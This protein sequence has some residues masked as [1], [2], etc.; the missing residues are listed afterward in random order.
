MKKNL[1]VANIGMQ[2]GRA[3]IEGALSCGAEIGAL[4]DLDTEALTSTTLP[5]EYSGPEDRPAPIGLCRCR[6]CKAG[7]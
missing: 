3:H 1:V 4:C 5:S 6:R 7:N 2:F